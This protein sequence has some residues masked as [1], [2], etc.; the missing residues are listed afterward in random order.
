MWIDRHP[1]IFYYLVGC[2]LVVTL[3][4][5]KVV[6]FF[7]IDWIIKANIVKKNLQ[8]VLPPDDMGFGVK[9]AKFIGTIMVEALFSW[10]NVAV[11][12]WQIATTLLRV[13][14]DQLQST[15]EGIKLLR[16]PLRNN[17][18]MP[19]ESVWAYLEALNLKAAEKLPNEAALVSSLNQV[20]EHYPSF[21]RITALNQLESLNVISCDVIAAALAQVGDE[22]KER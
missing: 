7:A 14:R 20:A 13:V 15:P 18:D 10:I 4:V 9:A 1:Y 5:I 22:K 21:D 16:W 6:L 17:P 19:R 3:T 2:V 8:K 11:V 12:L